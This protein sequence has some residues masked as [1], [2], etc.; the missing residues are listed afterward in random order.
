MDG[1][2]FE[3]IC[4][5]ELRRLQKAIKEIK[6]R[7]SDGVKDNIFGSNPK[8]LGSNPSRSAK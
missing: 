5:R 2:L 3:P 8:A 4:G 1:I 7:Q 6:K